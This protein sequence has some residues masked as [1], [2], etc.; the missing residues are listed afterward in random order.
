M[1]KK[2]FLLLLIVH[3]TIVR[4]KEREN[5]KKDDDNTIYVEGPNKKLEVP[6]IASANDNGGSGGYRLPNNDDDED[7]DDYDDEEPANDDMGSSEGETKPCFDANRDYKNRNKKSTFAYKC[8]EKGFFETHQIN[9]F[10]ESYCANKMGDK[11]D[12]PGTQ[13]TKTDTE[14]VDISVVTATSSGEP[15]PPSSALRSSFL[16]HPGLLAAIIGGA[17][18]GLLCAVLLVMFLVYRMK[19]KD[20][21]SYALDEPSKRGRSPA[22]MGYQKAPSKEYYA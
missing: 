22:H 21:G 10:G 19:K 8:D 15:K 9:E 16:G 17:V 13:K 4:S 11:V 3:V 14:R 2:L 5:I 12:C 6:D 1:I 7:D 18:V 20:E